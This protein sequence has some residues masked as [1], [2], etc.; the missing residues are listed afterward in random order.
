[1]L[2]T[3]R[4]GVQ[5]Q[6]VNGGGNGGGCSLEE[7]DLHFGK[8]LEIAFQLVDNWLDFAMDSRDIRKPAAGPDLKY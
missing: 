8:K 4:S 1:M 3:Y 2:G 7:A 6:L 5:K